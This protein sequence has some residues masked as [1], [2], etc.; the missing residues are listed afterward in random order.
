MT[1]TQY[2]PYLICS[3]NTFLASNN[4][5]QKVFQILILEMITLMKSLFF[6]YTALLNLAKF[7]FLISLNLDRHIYCIFNGTNQNGFSPVG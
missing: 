4:S 5:S 2:F 1:L 7:H 6:Y 3:W